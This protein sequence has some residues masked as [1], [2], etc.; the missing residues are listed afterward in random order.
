MNFK[1]FPSNKHVFVKFIIFNREGG[2]KR[3]KNRY[4][5]RELPC[6]RTLHKY[7]SQLGLGQ[8]ETRPEPYAISQVATQGY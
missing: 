7:L 8:Y 4:R 3:D 5:D 6:A 2:N 1:M